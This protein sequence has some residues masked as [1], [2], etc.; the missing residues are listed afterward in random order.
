MRFPFFILPQISLRRVFVGMSGP[1]RH[2]PA[3]VKFAYKGARGYLSNFTRVPGPPLVFEGRAYVSIEHAFHAAKLQFS[4]HVPASEASKYVV[5]GMYAC[6]TGAAV[7]RTTSARMFA[8]HGW[9][10][11]VPAWTAA[12]AGVMRRLVAAR[13][14]VDAA[15]VTAA[16]ALVCAHGSIRHRTGRGK[17]TQAADE[18]GKELTLLGGGIW[19]ISDT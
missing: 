8:A 4:K 11:D 7:K 6:L 5:G 3:F 13:A 9:N 15:Y 19:R 17:Y 12:R 14:E 1:R 2:K 10:L 18:L 16:R